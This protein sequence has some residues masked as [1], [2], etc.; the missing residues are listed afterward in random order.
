M[1]EKEKENV[2]YDGVYTID[3]KMWHASADQPSM[4][5]AALLKPMQVVVSTDK[6]TGKTTAVLRMEYAPLTTSG[7]EGYLAELNYFPGWEGGKTGYD[8]PDGETPVPA[9]VESYYEDTYDSYNDPKT[10]TD[11]NVKGKLYPHIMNLTLD[12]LGDS[13]V[14]VQ[15]YVPVMEALNTGSGRQYAKIQLDWD[16]RKQISGVET[17]KSKLKKLIDEASKLEQGEASDE[18]FAALQKMILAATDV[19]N[20]MNAGQDSV[21]NSVKALQ[22]A[23][24]ALTKDE[25]KTDKSEL[26]KAIKA[27]DSYL[28]NSDITYSDA[29]KALLQQARD[30]AQKVFDDENASQ[31][32]VNKCIDAINKAI[33]SL[34]TVGADKTDLKKALKNA[35]EYLQETSKYTAASIGA[36]K[37]AYD[38]AKG[39]YD[40]ANASQDDVDSQVRVLEYLMNHMSEVSEIEVDKSGLHDLLVTASNLAG[41]EDLYTKESISALKKVIKP[42]RS[43]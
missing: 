9:T 33:E 2:V 22:A 30:E 38:T 42:L 43:G 39:V 28:N 18:S 3:G 6:E 36:L 15:V 14:W 16:S 23:I 26:K 8:M 35:K 41:R 17:D 12:S 20:S 21:D 1:L 11:S 25:V 32:Q 27:A 40:D 10:G 29:S 13:E 19:Y 4:G 7:F 37:S 31:T 34:E 5:N 24:D